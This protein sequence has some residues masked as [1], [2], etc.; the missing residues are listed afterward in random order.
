MYDKQGIK[1]SEVE[2]KDEI[3]E[4]FKESNSNNINEISIVIQPFGCSTKDDEI[5]ESVK[6]NFSPESTVRFIQLYN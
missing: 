1:R 3:L 2:K 5:L 4:L 6:L